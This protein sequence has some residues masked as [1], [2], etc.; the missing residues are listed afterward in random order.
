MVPSIFDNKSL[1]DHTA[2]PAWFTEHIETIPEAGRRLLEQYSG[3]QPDLVL[4]RVTAV[5]SR[6][7]SSF[8]H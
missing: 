2:R 4:P 5:V 1:V 6:S 3:I 7:R 8:P